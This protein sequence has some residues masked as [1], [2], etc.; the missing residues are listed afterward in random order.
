MMFWFTV[1][2]VLFGGMGLL[3]ES[4]MVFKAGASFLFFGAFFLFI[5]MKKML[6]YGK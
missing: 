4:D 6:A 5:T 3:F 2:G 1:I